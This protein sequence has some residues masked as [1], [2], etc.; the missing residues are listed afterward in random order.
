MNGWCEDVVCRWMPTLRYP[1]RML[2]WQQTVLYLGS[3]ILL[4][5]TIIPVFRIYLGCGRAGTYQDVKARFS[6]TSEQTKFR[7][8][9]WSL[10][11]L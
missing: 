5:G 9:R 1:L 8:L 7:F 6:Y 11:G 10:T 4:T 2:G 3:Y